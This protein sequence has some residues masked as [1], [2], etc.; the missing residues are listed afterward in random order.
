M[1]VTSLKL[2]QNLKSPQHLWVLSDAAWCS[3]I[4]QILANNH[5]GKILDFFNFFLLFFFLLLGTV[6]F[7]LSGAEL[8]SNSFAN[9]D[10]T[11][12]RLWATLATTT[13]TLSPAVS[14][15]LLLLLKVTKFELRWDDTFETEL[16]E[17]WVRDKSRWTFWKRPLQSSSSLRGSVLPVQNWYKKLIKFKMSD[18]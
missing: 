5:K 11:L 18:F 9:L 3:M 14:L 13:T 12:V 6:V 8:W 1:V 15:F 2:H 17:L 7:L 16:K 4:Q 10:S